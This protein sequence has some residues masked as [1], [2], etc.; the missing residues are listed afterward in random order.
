[1]YYNETPSYQLLGIFLFSQTESQHTGAHL[2]G[3][4][5]QWWTGTMQGLLQHESFKIYL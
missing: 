5:T 4:G 3:D 1:M 2:Y